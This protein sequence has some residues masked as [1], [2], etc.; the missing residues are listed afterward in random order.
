MSG[1]PLLVAALHAHVDAPA[2]DWCPAG[3]DVSQH[4]PLRLRQRVLSLE[5]LTVGARDGAYRGPR[6]LMPFFG[7]GHLVLAHSLPEDFAL[8]RAQQVQRADNSPHVCSADLLVV[9]R[10]THRRVAEQHLDFSALQN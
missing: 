3:C 6:R 4:L 2:Q 7:H 5:G 1:T 9:R 10:R 8:L